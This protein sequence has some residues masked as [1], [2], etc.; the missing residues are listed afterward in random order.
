VNDTLFFAARTLEL[1]MELWRS[2]GTTAGTVLVKDIN[3]SFRGSNP[4]GLREFSGS[5]FFNANDLDNGIQLWRSDG[6]TAGTVIA[7]DFAP[8]FTGVINADFVPVGGMIFFTGFGASGGI[9]QWRTDGTAAGTVFL[10]QIFSREALE[11][12]PPTPF[13]V[14]AGGLFYFTALDPAVG[15]ELFVSGGTPEGTR[16]VREIFPGNNPFDPA[17]I[18]LTAVGGR[19]FFTADDGIHGHELWVTD[20]TSEGTMMVLDIFPS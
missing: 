2:D 10:K 15:M 3:P 19:V 9:E 5:L 11:G 6:T 20:G 16:L 4:S 13:H 8:G 1:G 7:S 14:A 17:P 18:Q 12:H